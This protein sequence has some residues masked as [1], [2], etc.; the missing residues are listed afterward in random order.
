[1]NDEDLCKWLR[2]HSSGIYRNSELGADRIEELL[3]KIS[4]LE[5]I[6]LEALKNNKIVYE[7]DYSGQ[8]FEEDFPNVARQV[9]E[10]VDKIGLY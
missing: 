3:K 5:N 4:Q 1:M 9:K 7:G 8:V 2:D 6:V 10:S